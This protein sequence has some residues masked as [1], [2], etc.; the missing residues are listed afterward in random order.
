MLALVALFA[1]FPALL[2]HSQNF[3]FIEGLVSSLSS[4][5]YSA[6]SQDLLLINSTQ[7]GQSILANLS[8][9]ANFTI[10]IP[11]NQ[12]LSNFNVTNITEASDITTVA[13]LIAYHIMPGDFLQPNDTSPTG[14]NATTNATLISAIFPNVTVGRTLL[15]NDTFV[16]LEG[17]KSQVLAWTLFPSNTSN[18]TSQTILNQPPTQPNVTVFNTTTFENLLLAFVTGVI[19]PPANLTTVL[20]ANNATIWPT[21]LNLTTF[22]NSS[23]ANTTVLDQLGVQRGFTAFIPSDEALS[24]INLGSLQGNLTNLAII[25]QNHIINDTTAYS[26][27]LYNASLNWT[28]AAGEPFTFVSN[29]TGN[30]VTVGMPGAGGNE[31]ATAQIVQSDVLVSNGVVH[32]IDAPLN[33]T[34]SDASAASSAFSSASSAATLTTSATGPIGSVF[35]SFSFVTS[36]TSTSTTSSSSSSPS[37]TARRRWA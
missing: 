5:G 18:V 4:L 23:G 37:V 7:V 16:Q 29:S 15:D 34:A 31:T 24:A 2:A 32:I 11:S 1:L 6:F 25:V 3:T 28:S 10:F 30:F 33:V 35:T 26:P 21:V 13:N 20:G 19:V 12:A 27:L 22:T 14:G 9:G 17:D 8:S 36:S